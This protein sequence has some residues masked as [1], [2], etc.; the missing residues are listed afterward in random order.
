MRIRAAF[1]KGLCAKGFISKSG[2][3]QRGKSRLTIFRFKIGSRLMQEANDFFSVFLPVG[4][5]NA[6]VQWRE[7]ARKFT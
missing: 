4:A 7:P 6:D 3:M 1:K 2:M 5:R